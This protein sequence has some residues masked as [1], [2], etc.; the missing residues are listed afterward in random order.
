MEQKTALC[1]D[2]ARIIADPHGTKRQ[3][4][5][6]IHHVEHC[7]VCDPKV[8]AASIANTVFSPRLLQKLQ[9]A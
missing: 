9:H 2:A 1:D 7:S 8:V 6:M 3:F 5:R 4:L